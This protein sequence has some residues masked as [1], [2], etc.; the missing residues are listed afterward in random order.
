LAHAL[1]GLLIVLCGCASQ[2]EREAFRE[3]RNVEVRTYK[4]RPELPDLHEDSS[5][6]EFLVYAS[7]NNPGLE[8]AFNRWKA[9]LEKVPQA[10]ALPD[11][12]FNYT[13]FIMANIT[14][15]GRM[16]S[17]AI[18]AQDFP[19]L[20]KL[21]LRADVALHEAKAQQHQFEAARL[22]LHYEVKDAYYEYYYWGRALAIVNENLELLKHFESV[23]QAQFQAGIASN[24]D[25]VRAQVELGK[26]E[27]Q[28]RTIRDQQKPVVARLNAVLNRAI[29][30]PLP[31]PNSAPEEKTSISDEDAFRLLREASPE[32]QALQSEA[33]GQT[34]AIK[35]AKKNY[36]PDFSV[37]VDVMGTNSGAP[38]TLYTAGIWFTIPIWFGKNAASV[39]EARARREDA[40]KRQLDLCNALL[41]RLQLALYN[42]RDAWRKIDLYGK[43]LVPK[44]VQSLE[45]NRLAFEAGQATFLDLIDAERSLLDFQLSHERALA[46][47]AQRLAEIEMLIGVPLH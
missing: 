43:T 8:A 41:S 37:S 34:A 24:A 12:R 36:L 13:Y 40:V 46:N 44:A 32:L 31:I 33:E 9:A 25:V 4:P 47:R 39:R 10:R 23:A 1:A 11:P 21:L 16:L 38:N 7:L 3:F 22:R 45:V 29:D 14:A 30:A 42:Y 35:L 5:I 20:S 17:D 15:D 6:D 2:R 18:L 28:L 26:L 27:D 19:W